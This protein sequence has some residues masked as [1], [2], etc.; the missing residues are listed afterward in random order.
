[1]KATAH[2]KQLFITSASILLFT[3]TFLA[4]AADKPLDYQL[5]GKVYQW[6]GFLDQSRHVIPD[7]TS[8][9]FGEYKNAER[10]AGAHHILTITPEV[11][12]NGKQIIEVE[13]EYL[14]K[15]D[16]GRAMVGQYVIQSL[17]L[18]L[19]TNQ[20]IVS[21]TE[22]NEFD[23]FESNYRSAS[24]SNLIKAF[25][26]EWTDHID[27][28]SEGKSISNAALLK[29]FG[30][31]TKF[32]SE[33]SRISNVKQYLSEIAKQGYKQSRRAI[34]NLNIQPSEDHQIYTASF[35]YV[36]N[37]LNHDGENE[38]AQMGLE[39]EVK[40]VDGKLKIVSYKAKFLPPV[41]DLG[42]EIR[43]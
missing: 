13:L 43:C 31:N 24:Q 36:W 25:I 40:F 1:M 26:Y 15:P 23:N 7:S 27:K 42:A 14:S 32:S 12:E 30:V 6:Y 5:Q 8:V 18:D 10:T 41:T 9:D 20:I 28:L 33:E 21:K 22:L 39:L 38:L 3:T 35:Q 19:K 2:F 29:A 11:K 16:L 4:S 17:T 34:K 37:A